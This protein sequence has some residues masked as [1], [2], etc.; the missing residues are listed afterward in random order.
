MGCDDDDGVEV[1]EG[2]ASGG[3]CIWRLPV[4]LLGMNA[5]VV[6]DCM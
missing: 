6:T 3:V 5:F 1:D 4:V 2:S